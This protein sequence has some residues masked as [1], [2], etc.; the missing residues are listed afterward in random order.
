M[1]QTVNGFFEQTNKCVCVFVHEKN[2]PT[3]NE[4]TNVQISILA[5][6]TKTRI[7]K[8]SAAN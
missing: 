6:T 8:Q 2:Y 4:L 7:V 1:E 3:E 5:K